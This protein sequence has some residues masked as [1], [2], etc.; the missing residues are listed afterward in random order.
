M[1]RHLV[2]PA[3][4]G[5]WGPVFLAA[6]F[7]SLLT[8]AV[9][10]AAAAER[11]DAIHQASEDMVQNLAARI[12][13]FFVEDEFATFE[14]NETRVRLRLDLHYLEQVGWDLSPKVKINLQ[15]P[16]LSERLSLVLNDGTD[17][18]SGD[19]ADDD[20]E[21][22]LALRWVLDKGS[23]TEAKLDLGLRLKD[24]ALDPFVRLNLNASYPITENWRGRTSNRLY[25]YRK[26][27][28]R[29]DLRQYFDRRFDENTLLRSR[30]RI[31][32][33]DQN[34]HNPNLEQRFSL[35]KT[36]GERSAAAF[37]VLWREESYEDSEF[38]VSDLTIEPQDS[39]QQV[40]TRIRFR[41]QVGRPWFY[42]E[43]W[44][45]VEWAEE[46]DWDTLLGFRI[47]AEVNLGGI[48]S[49]QLDD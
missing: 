21:N 33:F 25:Y 9:A 43:F 14:D 38:S 22:D 45:V 42:L 44:P 46:R 30:T 26:V 49:Q 4:T 10:R 7:G 15:L 27:H 37:E 34:D 39:Y 17:D 6:L 12:D 18:D 40:I 13:R 31:Q 5:C 36:I 47:R 8:P 16:A 29:N 23:D 11:I 3:V 32:F 41:R 19:P 1:S 28:W 24:G 20:G 48:G 35:F 2:N